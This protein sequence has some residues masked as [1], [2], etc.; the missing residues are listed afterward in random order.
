[1]TT[2]NLHPAQTSVFV[3]GSNHKGVHGA[4]AA[5]HAARWCGARSGQGEGPMG[6]GVH[7][8]TGTVLPASYAIPTKSGPS[9]TL[10]LVEVTQHVEAFLDYAR[11]CPALTFQVTRIGC[12]LAGFK[13]EQIAPLFT[14]APPN[15]L[16]PGRWLALRDP[17][18][19]RVIVAGSRGVT[20]RAA[21]FA[22]I[23]STTRRLWGKSG[24]EIVSGMAAGPDTLAVDWARQAGFAGSVVPF[25][26]EWQRYGKAAG[27][28]RNQQMAW[29]GT[30]LLA[31]WDGESPGTRTMID[32]AQR[33][34]LVVRV[35]QMAARAAI[36]AD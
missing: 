17:G 11:Q 26:A 29:Y 3:F 22:K 14:D 18:V 36:A 27:M 24:F 32:M 20:D 23:E 10:P 13:D 1:M 31:F 6:A 4:G 21:V 28:I 19:A 16:L 9:T 15:C 30:H 8:P 25:P 7:A 5:R 34:G 35:V 33:D 2:P 12:G